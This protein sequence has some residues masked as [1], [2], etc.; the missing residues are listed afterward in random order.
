ME[1]VVY[2]LGA[3]FSAP[4]GLPL[5]RNFYRMSKDMYERDPQGRELFAD[6]FKEMDRITKSAM[7]W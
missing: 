3:G 5:M 2:I 4:F 6:V 7:D 1:K